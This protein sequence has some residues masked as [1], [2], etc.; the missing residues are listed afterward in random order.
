VRL[1]SV[2]QRV[3]ITAVVRSRRPGPDGVMRLHL[4]FVDREWP[5]EGLE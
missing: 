5:L 3:S 4:E 1:T 2:A